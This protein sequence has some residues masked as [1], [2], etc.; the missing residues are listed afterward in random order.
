M[1][2]QQRKVTRLQ[3]SYMNKYD[4]HMERQQK[5]K[6]LLRRRLICFAVIAVITFFSLFTF[7]MKQRAL[8]AEK[9][10]EY[11]EKQTEIAALRAEEASLLEEI[12]LL[13]DEA[14][15][16][17]IAKT[18]YFFTEEGEIVFKLLDEAPAY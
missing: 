17:Q 5:R 12:S 18:N 15:V 4:A 9:Q 11:E 14:Y 3:S 13:E 6:R 7:H 2:S 16:L 10:A 8:H 1:E